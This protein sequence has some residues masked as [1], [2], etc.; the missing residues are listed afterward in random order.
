MNAMSEL[1]ELFGL[2][3]DETSS[4]EEKLSAQERWNYGLMSGLSGVGYAL[5][6]D[7]KELEAVLTGYISI[8]KN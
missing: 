3:L 1:S 8:E 2:I 4:L 5:L 6:A 7:H